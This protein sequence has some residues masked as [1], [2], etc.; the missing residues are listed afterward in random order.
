MQASDRNVLVDL[1]HLESFKAKIHLNVTDML[2]K[3]TSSHTNN[4]ES[5][6]QTETQESFTGQNEPITEETVITEDG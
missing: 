2:Q 5:P 4:D 6:T 3:N 1:K